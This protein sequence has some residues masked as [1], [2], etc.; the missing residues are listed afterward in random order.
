MRDKDF[1]DLKKLRT[2]IE[3]KPYEGQKRTVV[4]D[5]SPDE[6]ED[7]NVGDYDVAKAHKDLKKLKQ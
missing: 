5:E 1:V 3:D 6:D 7:I 2:W 4:V